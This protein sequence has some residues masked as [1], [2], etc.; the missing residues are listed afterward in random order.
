[1]PSVEP[2]TSTPQILAVD[3]HPENLKVLTKLLEGVGYEALLANNG[4]SALKIASSAK[5]ALILLDIMMPEMDGYMVCSALKSDSELA[6][7]P[8]IFISAM[9]ETLDKVKAFKAGAVDYITKPFQVEEA[10]ARIQTHVTL[11]SMQIHLEELVNQRTQELKQ[12]NMERKRAEEKVR[13]LNE[14]LERR[15]QQRT[16]ELEASI[17]QLKKTQDQMVESQK[18]AALGGLVSGVAHEINTPVGT[19]VT[20][21]SHL[22]IQTHQLAHDLQ[23]SSLMKSQLDSYINMAEE[24][25]KLIL[26]SLERA[27]EHINSF[28]MVAVDQLSEAKR[29]FLLKKYIDD[30]LLNL[31][32]I[33]KSS[34]HKISIECPNTLLLDSYPGLYSQ[35]ITNLVMNSITHG[36]ESIQKGHI[37]IAVE[38]TDTN[39][40]LDYKDDGRG[41]TEE[42]QEHL[43]DPFF[44]TKRGKGCRG[45][46]AFM[47]YNIVYHAL[48][49]ELWINPSPNHGVHYRITVPLALA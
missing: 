4:K 22:E 12:E 18:M 33:L 26:S 3:D 17:I 16:A 13:A 11:R 32:P 27:S 48:K 35:I 39:L 40:I 7:I 5:P 29:T 20:A 42:E 34:S 43:F 45:L 36:F 37:T 49:G 47:V 44:T 9:G 31:R 28:K 8:V 46:G 23:E 21:A 25:A 19:C 41:L 15:V 6:E 14:D 24:S 1:M 30:V 2:K 38:T 10:L